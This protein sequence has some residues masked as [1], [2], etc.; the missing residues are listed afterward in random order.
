[1]Y[2]CTIIFSSVVTQLCLTLYD[3]MNCSM[4]DLPVHHQL[5][6]FTQTHIHRVKCMLMIY[7][8]SSS[9]KSFKLLHCFQKKI[10]SDLRVR[11]NLVPIYLF[12]LICYHFNQSIPLTYQALSCP[13]TFAHTSPCVWSVHPPRHFSKYPQTS[14]FVPEKGWHERRGGLVLLWKAKWNSGSHIVN[15]MKAPQQWPNTMNFFS[16]G[17]DTEQ[18]W[19]FD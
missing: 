16:T 5:P 9:K 1:M 14:L 8:Q 18:R 6:K 11:H 12:N 3:P 7:P 10:Q 13:R 19:V 2:I 4:P 17:P 15:K